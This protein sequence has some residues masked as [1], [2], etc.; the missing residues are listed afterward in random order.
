[1]FKTVYL[2]S[3]SGMSVEA[4]QEMVVEAETHET[5]SPS[6]SSGIFD[7]FEARLEEL[8]WRENRQTGSLFVAESEARPDTIIQISI[9][10]GSLTTSS[11]SLDETDWS[12]FRTVSTPQTAS[13]PQF[14]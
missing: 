5:D 13:S 6:D 10:A 11:V 14:D 2:L 1:M 7:A 3:L 12:E 8:V 4:L 9:E